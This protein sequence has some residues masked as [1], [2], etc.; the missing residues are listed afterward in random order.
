MSQLFQSM[1]DFGALI[2]RIPRT[3]LVYVG[4]QSYGSEMICECMT[5]KRWFQPV[6]VPS[7]SYQYTA[8]IQETM[9]SHLQVLIRPVRIGRNSSWNVS[10]TYDQVWEKEVQIW[11]SGLGSQKKCLSTWQRAWELKLSMFI[12]KSPTKSFRYSWFILKGV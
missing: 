11:L 12:R 1:K 2:T 7:L 3:P 6:D 4:L 10:R 5:M 9:E 8:S